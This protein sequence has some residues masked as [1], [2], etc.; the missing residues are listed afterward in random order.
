MSNIFINP[1]GKKSIS[2]K[3]IPEE[4]SETVTSIIGIGNPLIDVTAQFDKDSIQ[5]LGIETGRT[6]FADEKNKDFFTDLEKKS[7]VSYTPG[8][9]IQNALRVAS[10]CLKMNN[11]NEHKNKL[12]MLGCVGDDNYKQK[13]LNALNDCGVTPLLETIP[14]METSRCGVAVYKKERCYLIPEIKASG[15]LSEKFINEN[16]DE[17]Y[18]HDALLIEGHFLKEKFDICK[19][20]CFEYYKENKLVILALAA[21]FV[22]HHHQDKILEIANKSNMII[23][24]MEEAEFLAEG[25]GENFHDTFEKIHKKLAPFD[26]ILVITAGHH[27]VFCSKYNYK[28]MQFDFIL[29]CFPPNFIKSDEITD[30]NGVGDAFLGGF[31]SQYLS[32]KSLYSCCKFGNYAASVVL[33]NVGCTFPKDYKIKTDEDEEDEEENNKK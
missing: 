28:T 5:K 26:R 30:L 18:S 20:L 15:H 23:G 21:V 11:K 10:W 29:Q 16:K 4:N 6:I 12:T 32:G 3:Q 17:I 22:V 2:E 1:Q 19:D 7:E 14:G 31:L 13:I 27:G 25:K 24:N 9:S 8:G 33:H